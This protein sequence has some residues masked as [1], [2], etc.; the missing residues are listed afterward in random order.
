MSEFECNRILNFSSSLVSAMGN[1]VS[2]VLFRNLAWAV[3]G[4]PLTKSDSV[5]ERPATSG[6]RFRQKGDMQ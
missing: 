1:S 3:E 2:D 6:R 5:L 4:M